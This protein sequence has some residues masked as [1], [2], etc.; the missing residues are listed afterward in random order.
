MY[1]YSW[2]PCCFLNQS[3]VLRC[4]W[5]IL[6]RERSTPWPLGAPSSASL[7]LF[8]GCSGAKA[9]NCVAFWVL[10][11]LL[12]L[13]PKKYPGNCVAF[14]VLI[15]LLPLSPKKYPD[16]PGVT[17]RTRVATLSHPG[18]LAVYL[19]VGFIEGRFRV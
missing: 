6:E 1:I 3:V 16:V 17:E 12:P 15:L 9:C 4:F 10:I 7:D 13:S 2:S 18:N 19:A 5:L 14:W 8:L 11:L